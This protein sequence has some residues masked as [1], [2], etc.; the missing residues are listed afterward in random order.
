[1]EVGEKGSMDIKKVK[2]GDLVEFIWTQ[3]LG[4]Y[5]VLSVSTKNNTVIIK[6]KNGHQIKID[7]AACRLKII[8]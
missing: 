1:M 6:N 2:Q 8:S 4:T 3:G 5:N 7:N